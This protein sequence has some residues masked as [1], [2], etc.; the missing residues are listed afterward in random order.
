MRILLIEDDVQIANF[1]KSLL[2][3]HDITHVQTL[4]DA[5][6]AKIVLK[7][8]EAAEYDLVLLDLKTPK[9][10]G[11]ATAIDAKESLKI[12]H[13]Q[14][15]H[16]P[17]I[18]ISAYLD[19]YILT[20]GHAYNMI[21]IDKSL[22]AESQAFVFTFQSIIEAAKKMRNVTLTNHMTRKA[23]DAAN[24]KDETTPMEKAKAQ[25]YLMAGLTVILLPWLLFLYTMFARTVLKDTQPIPYY[26]ETLMFCGIV[27]AAITG[28]APWV[29]KFFGKK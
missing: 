26:A 12:A 16:I 8:S 9:R 18:V 3:E 1:E 7:V 4:H 28:C 14:F 27:I 25:L 17:V 13:E 21:C 15:P 2:A 11:D 6:N 23:F 20:L 22:M 5:I 10:T 19:E 29:L 24:G